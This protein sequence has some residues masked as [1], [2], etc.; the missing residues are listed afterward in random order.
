MNKKYIL[1]RIAL[2]GAVKSAI[3]E[4]GVD[5]FKK[6]SMFLSNERNSSE[7]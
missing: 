7:D 2:Y 1:L 4:I 3:N 6:T 5:E